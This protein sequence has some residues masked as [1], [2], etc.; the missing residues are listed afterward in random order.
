MRLTFLMTLIIGILMSGASFAQQS[1]A[2]DLSSISEPLAE[3]LTTNSMIEAYSCVG[4]KRTTAQQAT[5]SLEWM[6]T[7]DFFPNE[8]VPAEFRVENTGNTLLR[9][10]IHPTL[11]DL[12]PENRST[13]FAYYHLT[14][15]LVAGVPAEGTALVIGGLDLY[16]S[17][18]KPDTFV[19]VA[20][21]ESIR[22]KGD[23]RVR[24]WYKR[25]HAITVAPGLS[26]SLHGF[27]GRQSVR[28]TSS[29]QKCSLEISESEP[30]LNAFMH[31]QPR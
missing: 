6:E 10:P 23:V 12:L 5:I 20:P 17:L 2:I 15:G 28:V 31:S 14:L 26:L 16:G 19:S 11:T 3:E 18:K 8:R 25:D 4:S 22:V 30:Q 27:P 9:L 29:D 7:T 24:R 13:P 21:G 1:V